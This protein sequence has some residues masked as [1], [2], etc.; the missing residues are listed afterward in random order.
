MCPGGDEVAVAV[1]LVAVTDNVDDADGVTDNVAADAD[2][3]VDDG[4]VAD[5]VSICCRLP[6]PIK[7]LGYDL[8]E[9]L[10]RTT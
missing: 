6:W 4:V 5:L 1:L 8:Q 7:Q 2:V 3:D 10:T 9:N